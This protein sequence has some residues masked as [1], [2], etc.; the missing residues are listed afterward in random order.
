MSQKYI[1]VFSLPPLNFLNF[2]NY[3]N[4]GK[5]FGKGVR[6]IELS[7]FLHCGYGVHI[8]DSPKN[9]CWKLI[10]CF[11]RHVT[12]GNE[13]WMRYGVYHLHSFF[14]E[15][16]YWIAQIYFLFFSFRTSSVKTIFGPKKM[17]RSDF[18]CIRKYNISCL[19]VKGTSLI[20]F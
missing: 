19:E 6:K 8:Y 5:G 7:F 17:Q 3:L 2:R 14:S 16:I 13:Q 12:K 1:S 4:F 11:G 9:E 10:I 15:A 18:I 20:N